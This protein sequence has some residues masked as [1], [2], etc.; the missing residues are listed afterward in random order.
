MR[1]APVL[2][3]PPVEAPTITRE[4][5]RPDLLPELLT[6]VEEKGQVTVHCSFVAG[7]S[8]AIRIWPSTFLMCRH[9]GHRSQ[10]LFA[11]GIPLAPQW[12]PVPAGN[13]IRF[14]LLF[15]GLPS[16]C[17]LFDLVEE[18]ADL[19][20]FHGPAILRNDMDVYRVEI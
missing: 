6:D 12:L 14:T 20:G 7:L 11:E 8:D 5:E 2:S 18:I 4:L 19:G 3:L 16:H 15:A 1:T 17:V 10:L 13:S 9:S